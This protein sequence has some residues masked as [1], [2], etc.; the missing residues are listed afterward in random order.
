MLLCKELSNE[1]L[2][3]VRMEIVILDKELVG[4][5]IDTIAGYQ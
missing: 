2:L 1:R 4:I 5:D 3:I